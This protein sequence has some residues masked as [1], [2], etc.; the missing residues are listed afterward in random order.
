MAPPNLR[1]PTSIIGRTVKAVLTTTL[2]T[3]ISN[4]AASGKLL[5][6]STILCCSK[7]LGTAEL[8][9]QHHDGSSGEP[10]AH[11]FPVPSKSVQLLGSREATINLEEGQSLQGLASA[12][13][14]LVLTISLEEIS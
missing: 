3:V 4:A 11:A 13:G 1:N 6:I 7:G 8:T 14:V 5:R 12:S 10:L 2:S 9:L